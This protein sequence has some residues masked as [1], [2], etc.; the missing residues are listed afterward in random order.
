MAAGQVRASKAFIEFIGREKLG[1]VV[2]K[3]KAHLAAFAT[4]A[5]R[6][7]GAAIGAPVPAAAVARGAVALTGAAANAAGPIA[8]RSAVPTAAARVAAT[9]LAGGGGGRPDAAGGGG[10]ASIER[11][12]AV[13]RVAARDIRFVGSALDTVGGGLSRA[14][15]FARSLA[16]D[17]RNVGFTMKFAGVATLG[18]LAAAAR[19]FVK[20]GSDAYDMS[21]RLGVSVEAW[22]ELGYAAV[23]AGADVGALETAMRKMQDAVIQAATGSD[24]AERA[25]AAIGLR[26]S[27]LLGLRPEDQLE[28][29]ADGIASIADPAARTAIGLDVFG[30]SAGKLLPI[31]IG[32]SEG[33]RALREEA[34]RLGITISTADAEVADR[35]GD[36]FAAL[37]AIGKKAF[38]A[39]GA[40]LEP[41]LT[42]GV[43]LATTAAG[44]VTGW[45]KAN[46]GLVVSVAAIGAGLLAAGVALAAL[47]PLVSVAASAM[48]GLGAAVS[49]A[50][51]TLTALMSPIGLAGA[52]AAAAV[53]GVL[54]LT[55]AF[56]GLVS[57][58]AARAV[59][60]F[61]ELR[62]TATSTI[63]GVVSA[64]ESGN[65]EA[66]GQIFWKGL[67]VA[68]LQ[69]K[70]T[71]LDIWDEIMARIPESWDQM[72]NRMA[73]AMLSLGATFKIA[74]DALT[75]GLANSFTKDR[76]ETPRALATMAVGVAP[77]TRL[78][79]WALGLG[80]PED[81][82]AGPS[83]KDA[84]PE[85]IATGVASET[86]R[87]VERIKE[88][89]A[90]FDAEKQALD[91]EFQR[92]KAPNNARRSEEQ[93]RRQAEIDRAKFDL[94]LMRGSAL[95]EAERNR[96]SARET[97]PE[98]GPRSATSFDEI[99]RRLTRENAAAQERSLYLGVSTFSGSRASSI[100]S[101]SVERMSR[102]AERT[103]KN[104]EGIA[105]IFRAVQG[106]DLSFGEG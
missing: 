82:L 38:F 41:T 104:T 24:G 90:Q 74:Q 101:P 16:A 21:Q 10:R 35:L 34:R 71:L 43:A 102:A 28:R 11:L 52:G 55:G 1:P 75:S 103:A 65:T 33:V 8:T 40:A 49:L 23:Q 3:A 99:I 83:L 25:L 66:A 96:S 67:E 95:L 12:G 59:G 78:L 39:I 64:L 7:G 6:Y 20:A 22:S 98:R 54:A 57:T 86:R 48:V 94:E 60:A 30:R 84:R 68:T 72:I 13:S 2:A 36:S 31:L 70:S 92:Q 76:N 14:G 73:L 19:T 79:M 26:A 18:F 44:S 9:R 61:D 15:G 105:D 29:I 58:V 77:G 81:A 51:A 80:S 62:G 27:D 37:G 63:A 91:A 17:M 93:A 97:S 89:Q 56:D 47:A 46:E 100:A 45:V 88:I 50:G 85:E 87:L 53:A 32:G 4:A 5:K 106:L 69:A 42:K